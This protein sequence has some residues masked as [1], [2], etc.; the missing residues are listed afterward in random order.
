MIGSRLPLG[1]V[2]N[3][4]VTLSASS[5]FFYLRVRKRLNAFVKWRI[6]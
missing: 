2:G 6:L 4:R 1:S 3:L 5:G